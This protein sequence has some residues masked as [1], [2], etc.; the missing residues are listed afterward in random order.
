MT[1]A[2]QLAELRDLAVQMLARA[3]Q[4]LS[5]KAESLN[6][7]EQEFLR[8]GQDHEQAKAETGALRRALSGLDIYALA[9]APV[10]ATA[11]DSLS[12]SWAKEKTPS[13]TAWTKRQSGHAPD[14]CT[15]HQLMSL[16]GPITLE[17]DPQ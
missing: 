15:S 10:G 4:N 12:R 7:A 11:T 9:V 14:Q 5:A 2:D 8:A 17:G 16:H 6:V 13:G 1:D 3:E